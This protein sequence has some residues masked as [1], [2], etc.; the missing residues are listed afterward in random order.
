MR[1]HSGAWPGAGEEERARALQA[2]EAR[3]GAVAGLL[4]RALQL[5]RRAEEVSWGSLCL[6]CIGLRKEL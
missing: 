6:C 3:S 5:Q 1:L 4:D 2:A